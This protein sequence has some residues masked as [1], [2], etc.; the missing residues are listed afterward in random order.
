[1]HFT[2][3]I[4]IITNVPETAMNDVLYISES[5]HMNRNITFR[6]YSIVVQYS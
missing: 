1:M 4:I 5:N 2:L 6:L 3:G